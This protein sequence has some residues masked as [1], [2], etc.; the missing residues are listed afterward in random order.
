MI[1]Y[2][3]RHG[4]D[5]DTVRGG[6][7]ESPLTDEGILQVKRLSEKILSNEQIHIDKIYTSDL[8]RAKQTAEILSD[9]LSI[10]FT[11]SP[12]FRETDNG[13]LAGMAHRLAKN[14]F[15]GYIG[16]RWIGMSLTPAEKALANFIIAFQRHGLISKRKHKNQIVTLHLS[17]TAVLST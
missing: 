13:V 4:K 9:A 11:E 3:I 5:D 10:P 17:H 16:A 7:S 2:L 15:P 6:W 8:P 14:N 12:E 1:C